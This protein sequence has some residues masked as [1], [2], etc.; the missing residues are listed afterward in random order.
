MLTERHAH[1][2][3]AELRLAAFQLTAMVTFFLTWPLAPAVA[4]VGPTVKD[5]IEFTRIIQPLRHDD[6]TLQTQISPDGSRAFIVTR[7]ADVVTDINKFELLLLDIRPERLAAGTPAAPRRLLT[8][9]AQHDEDDA[10]PALREARWV[11]DRT[12]VLRARIADQLPQAYRLDVPTKRLTQLTYAPLGVAAF[13]VPTDMRRVVYVSPVPNPAIPA[14]TRSIVAGTN[15]FW[16]VHGDQDSFRTQQRRYQFFVA[17]AGSRQPARALGDAFAESSNGFPNASISPDGR[18]LL[19]PKY[20]PDRQIAWGAQY[21]KIAEAT[22]KYGP[23]LTL[24]PLG[25]YSRPMSYVSRRHVA[26]RLADGWERPVVDAPDDSLGDN[27]L[28]TDRLWQDDGKS[29]VVAGTFLPARDGDPDSSGS[30]HIIEYWP[31]T[32][33]WKS[34]GRLKHRLMAAHPVAGKAGAFIAMDGEQRRRFER[35]ADGSWQEVAESRPGEGPGGSAVAPWRLHVQQALN[36]PPDIVAKGPGGTSVRLTELNPQVTPSWGTMREYAW[37]DSKGRPWHGG[38]M[39]PANFDPRARHALVIQTY[40]FSPTRFYRDGSNLYDGFTSGFAG[41]AFMRENILVL[42]LPWRATSGAPTDEFGARTAFAEGVQGAID[43]L[44]G[45]GLVDRD[46]IG[47]LGWSATGERVLNLLTFTDTPI[48]AA[49]LLDGDANTLFSMSITYSVM[50]GIQAKKERANEGGPYGETRERWMRNDPSLHTDCIRAALRIEAY[51]P[52]VHNNWDIY[53]LLRRQ[54][55]PAELI[56]IPGGA[57]ALSRPS[58]RMISL[59]G[60]VD[61]YRFWLKGE[62]RV[63][64]LI[65]GESAASLQRQYDRWDQMATLKRAADAKADSMQPASG[66]RSGI[67]GRGA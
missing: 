23:S 34:I 26:Y 16:S 33:Q 31:D 22:I 6:D 66:C 59:Q 20:E 4:A 56:M 52:E 10:N 60:N 29:V 36:Q 15:S 7:R 21:P 9:K 55:R 24:D 5:V 63:E 32:G 57:H 27:Q 12:I 40:G 54:Y 53:A 17:A 39:L 47:I 65:P 19:L 43:A 1:L 14:G 37:K 45:E 61:W 64:V 51:G 25:Y 58:E 41:R 11:D 67:S 30:S 2:M 35:V 28:R 8:V 18:W 50:D 49:T 62:K 48:R 46:R 38:L 3:W 42:A 44:V 13:D